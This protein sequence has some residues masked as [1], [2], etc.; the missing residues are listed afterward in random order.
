MMNRI[1]KRTRVR[2]KKSKIELQLLINKT[3]EFPFNAFAIEKIISKS[4]RKKRGR[5]I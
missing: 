5:F 3:S 2:R 4:E 1:A